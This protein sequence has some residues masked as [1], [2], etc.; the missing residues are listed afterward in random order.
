M[1]IKL[2]SLYSLL[3]PLII[4]ISIVGYLFR[5]DSKKN[6]YIPMGLVGVSMIFDKQV[7]RSM[8]RKNILR[9]INFF[10]NN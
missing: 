8:K 3:T 5:S 7:Q 1:K 4:A 10:K 9:K 2:I 6:F